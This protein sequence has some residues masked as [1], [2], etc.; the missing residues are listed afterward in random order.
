MVAESTV[1]PGGKG[2]LEASGSGS[3]VEDPLMPVVV[4]EGSLPVSTPVCSSV[5]APVLDVVLSAD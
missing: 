3:E 4:L 5:C 1:P 2:T